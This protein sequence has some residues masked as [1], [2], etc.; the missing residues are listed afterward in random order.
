[1]K[2]KPLLIASAMFF[3]I[4]SSASTSACAAAEKAEQNAERVEQRLADT[5]YG[6]P[7]HRQAMVDHATATSARILACE[8]DIIIGV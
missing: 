6:S 7:A 3:S 2:I 5:E 1:M 4:Q 8:Y